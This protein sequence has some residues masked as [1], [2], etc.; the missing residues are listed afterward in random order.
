MAEKKDVIWGVS[1]IDFII[2]ADKREKYHFR[3]LHVILAQ[4]CRFVPQMGKINDVFGNIIEYTAMNKHD[5]THP[6]KVYY[7]LRRVK[8]IFGT[9]FL[10]DLECKFIDYTSFLEVQFDHLF[11]SIK[12]SNTER[13]Y[14]R[15]NK[16][17]KDLIESDSFKKFLEL[18]GDYKN[19]TNIEGFQNFFHRIK[20]K[21][22]DYVNIQTNG[23]VKAEE[24]SIAF[25]SNWPNNLF[26]GLPCPYTGKKDIGVTFETAT[27][28]RE[29][30]LKMDPKSSREFIYSLRLGDFQIFITPLTNIVLSKWRLP[31]LWNE[32]EM[33]IESYRWLIRELK[34]H[35]KYIKKTKYVPFFKNWTKKFGYLER[36]SNDGVIAD[37]Y[38][39]IF[40]TRVIR[41]YICSIPKEADYYDSLEELKSLLILDSSKSTKTVSLCVCTKNRASLLEKCLTSIKEQSVIPNELLIID[42]SDNNDSESTVEKFMKDLPIRYI[43]KSGGTISELR[44][45]AV[46]E[47]IGEVIAFTDDDAILDREWVFHVKRSFESDSNLKLMGGY[48][49]HWQQ[50]KIT[51]TELF[52]RYI[53]GVRT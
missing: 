8:H 45:F 4:F 1:D 27:E 5:F 30:I 47:A 26:W 20:F 29:Y 24:I 35:R 51:S 13:F 14:S 36:I 16:L 6:A 31:F 33:H 7:S 2:I 48:M 34:H 49:Y 39:Q 18:K 43:K 15:K 9:D 12:Q 41:D 50:D 3:Q 44:D 10:A 52:H 23:E 42:N 25:M 19:I 22:Y 53:L 28:L 46:K 32:S 21:N 38:T 40:N 17:L 11:R 37:R